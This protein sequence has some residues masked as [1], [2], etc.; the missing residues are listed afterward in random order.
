[1]PWRVCLSLCTGCL[2]IRLQLSCTDWLLQFTIVFL[3]VYS[4]SDEVLPSNYL[5][6]AIWLQYSSRLRGSNAIHH[7]PQNAVQSDSRNV[8]SA[9]TISF[10]CLFFLPCV[11]LSVDNLI[12]LCQQLAIYGRENYAIHSIQ[13]GQVILRNH[14]QAFYMTLPSWASSYWALLNYRT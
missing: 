6:S 5:I 8:Q 9:T 4:N 12:G 10:L 11:F 2:L 7:L 14:L 1:M 3:Q 13:F